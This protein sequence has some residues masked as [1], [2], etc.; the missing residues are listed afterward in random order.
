[1]TL[2]LIGLTSFQVYWINNAIQL[3][4]ERFNK[5][6]HESLNRVA[7]KLEQSELLDVAVKS[8][9]IFYTNDSSVTI[10]SYEKEDIDVNLEVVD[11]EIE[12]LTDSSLKWVHSS[13]QN[14]Q[15]NKKKNYETHIE[16]SSGNVRI[17]II[18]TGNGQNQISKKVL[19]KTKQFNTVVHELVSRENIDINTRINPREIDSLLKIEFKNKGID[20][21]FDFGILD[22]NSNHFV[23]IDTAQTKKE[24]LINSP[25]KAS[26][27]P[28]DILHNATFLV[29][30]FPAKDQFLFKK[31]LA[32]LS[33]SIILLLVII[34]CFSYAIYII[35]KQKKLSELKNDFINNMTHEFKTPIATVSLACEVLNDTEIAKE[36]MN[37]AKYVGVIKDET[38]RLGAQVER[39]LQA[40]TMDKGEL[41]INKN[42]EDIHRI[43]AD[44]ADRAQIQIDSDGGI[45]SKNLNA[46]NFISQLDGH[47]FYNTI[48]NLLDNALKYSKKAPKISISTLNVD[49]RIKIFIKDNGIGISKEK[50]KYIFEKFYRVSTGNI[51]DVK[52][53]GLG[54]NYVHYVIE[55][56][57]GIITVQSALGK[58]STFIIDL[59]LENEY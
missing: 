51:H 13:G 17:D 49:N 44:C 50:Q 52:G 31:I 6:V 27:F 57:S 23:F 22:D 30:N 53:F 14:D 58:G 42:Q 3:S 12:V 24:P 48:S 11:E 28:N 1:M 15:K 32:T 41:R 7:N 20:I 35:L 54:L 2:S 34:T 29:V 40:A 5:D 38:T 37:V 56:H 55:A 8:E 43:L 19:R 9:I 25:L 26:L 36:K 47:H 46:K 18:A 45:I 21:Y 59:P 16:D 33:S 4:N 10:K 39:V